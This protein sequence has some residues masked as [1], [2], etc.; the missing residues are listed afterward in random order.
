M[1]NQP[2]K[3]IELNIEIPDDLK[4]QLKSE[5]ALSGVALKEMAGWILVEFFK[6]SPEEK[7]AR[8]AQWKS[9]TLTREGSAKK[10]NAV[11][12][13]K[14]P[15]YSPSQ[16][17]LLPP[18]IADSIMHGITVSGD[19]MQNA[20]VTRDASQTTHERAPMPALPND[21]A[22]DERRL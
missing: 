7:A 2:N 14:L 10:T 20:K 11:S 3:K 17:P 8:L 18:S 1:N 5:A 9:T 19:G 4:R 12:P 21:S 15:F 16:A 13:K 22:V 6:L